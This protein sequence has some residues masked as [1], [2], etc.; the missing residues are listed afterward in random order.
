MAFKKIQGFYS[1]TCLQATNKN[2]KNILY[3]SLK[4]GIN[5]TGYLAGLMS[6]IVAEQKKV[7]THSTMYHAL[8]T[9]HAEEDSNQHH[10][11]DKE[12]KKRKSSENIRSSLEVI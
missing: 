12:N 7:Q 1:G 6:A 5:R 8:K 11:K 3:P 2:N 4:E 10:N 9:M